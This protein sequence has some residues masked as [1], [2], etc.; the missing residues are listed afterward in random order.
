MDLNATLFGQMIT[1]G[2][3]VWFTMKF[4]WPMLESSMNERAQK[5]SDGLAAAEK[6]H[7]TLQDS[8][9]KAK[10][11][12]QKA[13]ERSIDIIRRAETQAQQIIEDAKNQA[14]KERQD[15]VSSGHLEVEQAINLAKTELEQKVADIVVRGTEKILNRTFNLDDHQDILNNL[16]KEL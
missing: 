10:V 6:G 7:K 1:F 5:I 2:I 16:A 13:K 3:F 14:V 8:Q 4:V 12:V 9:Y 15:I 11:E